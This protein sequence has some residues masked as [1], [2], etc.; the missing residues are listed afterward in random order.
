MIVRNSIRSTLVIFI[1]RTPWSRL[2]GGGKYIRDEGAEWAR[3]AAPTL[4]YSPTVGS[5]GQSHRGAI[6]GVPGAGEAQVIL[7]E[8]VDGGMLQDNVLGHGGGVAVVRHVP[9]YRVFA[10]EERSLLDRGF[11]DKPL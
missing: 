8:E 7:Q 2:R 4:D 3:R 1:A 10:D 9:R 5:A 11:R 6:V